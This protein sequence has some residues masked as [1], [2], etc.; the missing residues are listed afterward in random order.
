MS[1][2]SLASDTV[3]KSKIAKGLS[4][5]ELIVAIA[6]VGILLTIGKSSYDEYFEK[7]DRA[8]AVKDIQIIALQVTDHN[9]TFGSYPDSLSELSINMI[10]PWGN[11]YQ[12]LAI[13]GKKNSG[14]TRKDHSLV[15]INSDFDLYSL[16]KD[17]KSS[18]PLTARA[19]QDDIVRASNGN[20]IGLGSDY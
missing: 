13:A 6:V 3:L 18:P 2:N 11:A 4:I 14:K 16:G 8:K 20:Y 10:D 12:Y 19:S 7:V 15:P 17:G 5:V 9:L 1:L